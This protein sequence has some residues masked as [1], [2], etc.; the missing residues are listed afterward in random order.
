MSTDRVA[1]AHRLL[2]EAV[3]ALVAAAWPGAGDDELL[4][5][6]SLSE[7]VARRLDRVVVG[8]V[9]D[10]E[11]RGTFAERGYKSAAGALGDLLGWERFEA[12]RRVVAADQV[13][14]RTGLDG[15]ALP[16]PLPATAA[17][18]A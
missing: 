18:F 4:S 11:R 8:A 3:D 14:A 9:A 5:V 2:V 16:A 12:R 17:E 6:L 15:A 1:A 13:C 7:G 10:L